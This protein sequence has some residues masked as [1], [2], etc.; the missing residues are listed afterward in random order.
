ME[1]TLISDDEPTDQNQPKEKDSSSS[2]K[3]K[4][5]KDSPDKHEKMLETLV[6]R[7]DSI[8]EL[9]KT[10]MDKQKT[11]KTGH[12]KTVECF[13]GY[14]ES[15]LV[16]I[17]QHL[18]GQYTGDCMSLTQSYIT[19]GNIRQDYGNFGGMYGSYGNTPS[20]YNMKGSCFQQPQSFQSHSQP[21]HGYTPRQPQQQQASNLGQ[22]AYAT[23]QSASNVPNVNTT[24]YN[25]LTAPAALGSSAGY[26]ETPNPSQQMPS[27]LPNDNPRTSE[28]TDEQESTL[29]AAADI[30]ALNNDYLPT[31]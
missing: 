3:K 28:T 27:S 16:K 9:R 25:P 6:N 21:V 22:N 8:E 18:W 20:S 23:Q 11:A 2:N 30:M 24:M 12:E 14:L 19:R 5:G 4:K 7:A 13:V 17:P 10:L 15:E 1:F 26:C 29:S 31:I